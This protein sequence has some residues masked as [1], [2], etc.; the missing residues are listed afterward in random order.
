MKQKKLTTKTVRLINQDKSGLMKIVI[1][2]KGIYRTCM[3]ILY[4]QNIPQIRFYVIY[5]SPKETSIRG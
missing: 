3:G 4:Q 5:F 2:L 1:H